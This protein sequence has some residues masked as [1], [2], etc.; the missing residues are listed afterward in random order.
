MPQHWQSEVHLQVMA[1]RSFIFCLIVFSKYKYC[2]CLGSSSHFFTFS[3]CTSLTASSSRSPIWGGEPL[4]FLM[5]LCCE[6]QVKEV[7]YLILD[8]QIFTWESKYCSYCFAG[9]QRLWQKYLLWFICMLLR[10]AIVAFC[11]S[12]ERG[13]LH[14]L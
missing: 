10:V 11:N 4:G 3:I 2:P 8:I 1:T 13:N 7:N 14:P 5:G 9:Y 6:Y 12:K